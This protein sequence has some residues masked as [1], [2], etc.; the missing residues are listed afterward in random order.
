VL[1]VALLGLDSPRKVTEFSNLETMI[2]TILQPYKSLL[3]IASMTQ[4]LRIKA[5]N[6]FA[7]DAENETQRSAVALKCI[8]ALE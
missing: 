1:G 3:Y 5:K 4:M 6:E 8:I 7:L 2:P